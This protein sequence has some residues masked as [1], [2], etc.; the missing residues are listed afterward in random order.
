MRVV[1][2]IA[3][4]FSFA[5][6]NG[7]GQGPQ[8]FPFQ[9]RDGLIWVEVA[10]S[11][12]RAPL[13]FLLDS[14]AQVSVI[15]ASTAQR[16][17]LKRGQRVVVQGVESVTKGYWVDGIKAQ[18]GPVPLG[19]HFLT[20]DLSRLSSSCTNAAVDGIIG[21][22]FFG[23]RIVQLDFRNC[24][25]RLLAHA[26]AE[27]GAEVVPLRVRPCGML[28]PIRVNGSSPEWVRL[29]TGC[30]S[31]LQWVTA[32]VQP[33]Q[34]TRRVAVGLASVQLTVTETSLLFAGHTF[35]KVPTD[36][37]ARE[38][39]PGERGLLGNGLL[40]RFQRVTVDGQEGQLWVE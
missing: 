24:R 28:V 7:A 22:D 13:H 1:C 34:C 4:L 39:F 37:H 12:A 21:A 30:A 20:L 3:A 6:C 15:N 38:V 33:E 17:G 29:D 36:V 16:L 9:Y 31:A 40:S 25:V 5:V 10:V 26:S 2:V 14:G 27:P 19:R 32:T 18:A 35:E 11:G 8:E 23:N